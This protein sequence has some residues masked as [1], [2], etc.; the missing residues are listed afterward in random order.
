MRIAKVLLL[1]AAVMFLFGCTYA[2]GPIQAP[3]TPDVKG[4]VAG[5]E[6]DVS[7]SKVGKAKAEGIL[8]FGH[9]DASIKAAAANG[10]ISKIHHV[11]SKTMNILGLYSEYTTVVYGE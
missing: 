4:P 11:D 1:V 3:L 2:N 7:A 6:N 10:D 9:G 8:F 5:F